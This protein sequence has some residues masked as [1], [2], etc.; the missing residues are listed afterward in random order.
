LSFSGLVVNRIVDSADQSFAERVF[1]VFSYARFTGEYY[2]LGRTF[3]FVHTPLTVVAASPLI[4]WGPGQ[5]G[6]GAASAL[7]NTAVYEQLK[8]PFGVFGTEGFI[9]NNWFSLWAEAGSIGMIFYL[10]IFLA[11]FVYALRTYRRSSDPYVKGL[12]IGFAAVLLAVTLN[13]FT[14][15]VLEIRTLAYYLWLYAGFVYVL[16]LEHTT[17]KTV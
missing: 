9:D 12:A 5:F 17:E 1:E 2:G 13:A 6:A 10:W 3:W 7:H 4:G 15:T 16:G 11:L 14:S 8:L